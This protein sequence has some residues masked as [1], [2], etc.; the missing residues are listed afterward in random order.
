MRLHHLAF[1][2]GDLARLERFYVDVLALTVLRRDGA[3]SVWLD[4]SG[5]ILMLER[6]DAGEVPIDASSK[7][8]VCFAIGRDE[9]EAFAVRLAA[10]G[11]G[12]DARTAFTMYFR[13]PDGRR[14]GLSSYPDAPP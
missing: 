11:V 6:R 2:T 14:V 5:T 12:I 8:L 1:R 4:A 7:E 13:D 3:Q 9:H 10:N